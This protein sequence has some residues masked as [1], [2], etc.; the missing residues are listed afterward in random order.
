[1]YEELLSS[2]A[3]SSGGSQYGNTSGI[4]TGAPVNV[5]S[6]GLNLGSILQPFNEGNGATGGY[7]YQ[8]L[9]RLGFLPNVETH[10]SQIVNPGIAG[11][12]PQLSGGGSV[13]TMLV[14][15]A[16]AVVGLMLVRRR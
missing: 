9:S 10:D 16:A 3:G 7:D 15:G 14:I 6:V 11:G 8:L 13:N 2:V 5:N 4:E 1:M 12:V